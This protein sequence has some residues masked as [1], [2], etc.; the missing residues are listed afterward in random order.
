MFVMLFF[1][2]V[3]VLTGVLA[4]LAAVVAFCYEVEIL[5]M[6]A[7]VMIMALLQCVQNMRMCA[8]MHHG[9]AIIRC[10]KTVAA[11]KY[12]LVFLNIPRMNVN[13]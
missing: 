3:V 1:A 2:L 11:H 6:A 7:I 5:I 9:S 4:L 12:C 8:I 10:C 13:Q